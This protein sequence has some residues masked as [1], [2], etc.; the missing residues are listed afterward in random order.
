MDISAVYVQ[1]VNDSENE[2]SS[3]HFNVHLQSN[4]YSVSLYEARASF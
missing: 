2:T 1:Y 4:I 3:R